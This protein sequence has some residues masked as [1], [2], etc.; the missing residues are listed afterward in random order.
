MPPSKITSTDLILNPDG[1]IYHLSLK[2][3]H[4][5]DYIIA[6]GDPGRVHKVTQYFDSVDYEMNK[7]EF[8][9]H[10]GKY[11]GRMITVISSGMGTDNVEILMMELDALANVDLETREPK[12]KKRK[13]KIIRVGTSGSIQEDIRLGTH[14]ISEFAIGMDPL[15]L[16]YHL[17]QSDL[18]NNISDKIIEDT[19]LPYR[20]YCVRGS[21]ML[22]EHIR[23]IGRLGNTVTCHG[24]YGPQG[25]NLRVPTKF[26]R[27]IENLNYFHHQDI[28]LT[29]LEMETAG[30][31]ALARILGHEVISV[32]AIIANR[33]RDRFSKDPNKVIDSLIRKVL[34]K[35]VQLP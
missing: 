14:L 6:V 10:V 32:N 2:P 23:D 26:P 7:R 24:F 13:L 34:D 25:R 22:I 31:Y 8:I 28:W 20:P 29:N 27:L 3:E 11:K 19:G 35:I 18:E 17:E 9:T 1:S 4:V 12:S 5:S 21:E 30:Y 15:M 33:I 16:Y